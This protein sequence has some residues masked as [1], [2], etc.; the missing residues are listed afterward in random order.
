M[1]QLVDQIIATLRAAPDTTRR[2]HPL[3]AAITAAFAD[4]PDDQADLERFAARPQRYESVLRDLLA[5]HLP[6]DVALQRCLVALLA[7]ETAAPEPAL[8][9]VTGGDDIRVGAITEAIGIAI[10][11]GARSTVLQF[12]FSAGIA[13]PS[14][15]QCELVASYLARLA[16]RCDRLRLSGAVRRERRDVGLTLTLSQVYVALASERW[17]P[18]REATYAEVFAGELE[19]GDPDNVLPEA[20]VASWSCS[21]RVSLPAPP[22][23]VLPQAS[24]ASAWIAPCC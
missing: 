21:V 11:A 5:E 20:A 14:E 8:P 24:H 6:Q 22:G 23:A 12:F 13:D 10:G 7:G 16:S 4:S 19:A 1:Q 2:S 18:L 3:L 15:E 9:A 17:E